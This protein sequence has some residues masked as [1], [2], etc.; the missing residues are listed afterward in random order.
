[1]PFLGGPA[2]GARDSGRTVRRRLPALAVALVLAALV[3][4][5]MSS[6]RGLPAAD[7]IPR[8]SPE[9]VAELSAGGWAEVFRTPVDR[10]IPL[11]EYAAGWQRLFGALE[12]VPGLR[13]AAATEGN[14]DGGDD[15]AFYRRDP[16]LGSAE[17]TMEGWWGGEWRSFAVQGV[18]Q[19]DPPHRLYEAA[20]WKGELS[21]F[22]FYGPRSADYE[23]LGGVEVGELDPGF[24]RITFRTEHDGAAWHL[25]AALTALPDERVVA[26][27][28]A[29]DA[30]LPG[31]GYQGIGLLSGRRSFVS[32]IAVRA[33]DGPDGAL[34]D[35]A[36]GKGPGALP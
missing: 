35:S 12:V 7:Q 16:P 34:A 23:S 22:Y 5:R 24:Y 2:A 1:M 10:A 33:L 27:V 25:D 4:L 29:T 6:R 3:V 32:G 11:P 36:G 20:L 15:Y 31:S 28:E 8:W 21:L 14:E 18:V 26:R 30:R 13:V 19:P 17:I 9:R